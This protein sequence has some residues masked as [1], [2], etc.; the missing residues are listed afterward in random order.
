M[1]ARN[2][3]QKWLEALEGRRSEPIAELDHIKEV[4]HTVSLTNTDACIALRQISGSVGEVAVAAKALVGEMDDHRDVAG[5]EF[6]KVN[7]E[8]DTRLERMPVVVALRRVRDLMK[9]AEA[10][11]AM[12]HIQAD[13]LHIA[14]RALTENL[15]KLTLSNT[16]V[17]RSLVDVVWVGAHATKDEIED[18]NATPA[19]EYRR[20]GIT[21]DDD[22]EDFITTRMFTGT[23]LRTLARRNDGLTDD[24]TDDDSDE[25]LKAVRRLAQVVPH[26]PRNMPR[27]TDL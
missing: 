7:A 26:S 22:G 15:N 21:Y 1:P 27:K 3:K 4:S 18:F 16:G 8:I 10:R 24:E 2:Y 23:S 25:E 19:G 6:G 5:L 20:N 12:L 13:D 11:I 17:K 14:N 9:I